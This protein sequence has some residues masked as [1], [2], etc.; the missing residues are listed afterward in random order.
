MVS[1]AGWLVRA[2][3]E[4]LE[5]DRDEEAVVDEREDVL[6]TAEVITTAVTVEEVVFEPDSCTGDTATA[7]GLVAEVKTIDDD[8][9]ELKEDGLFCVLVGCTAD[10]ATIDELEPLETSENKLDFEDAVLLCTAEV[11]DVVSWVVE[12]EDVVLWVVETEE[13][14]GSD[15]V[16]IMTVLVK[17]TVE[18]TA[19]EVADE[20]TD[21]AVIGPATANAALKATM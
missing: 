8:F 7:E 14:V 6:T 21:E 18:T 1:V 2:G 5:L 11:G 10:I 3:L 20:A 12:T 19:E 15:E 17:Y 4:R 9:D 16:V 13:E